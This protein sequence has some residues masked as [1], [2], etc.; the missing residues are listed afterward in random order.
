MSAEDVEL[1]R[2]WF[3]GLGRGDLQPELW[4]SELLMR[5]WE[6]NPIPGPFRGHDGLREWWEQFVDAF[7]DVSLEL[8]EVIDLGDGRLVTTQHVVGRF[9]STGIPVDGPFGAIIEIRDGKILSATGYASPGRA[10]KAAG[11]RRPTNGDS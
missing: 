5:N 9:R 8:K 11:L 1:I 6:E 7:K 4:H 10:K 3:D 2:R